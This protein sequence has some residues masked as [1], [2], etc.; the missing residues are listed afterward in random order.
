MKQTKLNFDLSFLDQN[1]V[2]NFDQIKQNNKTLLSKK[3]IDNSGSALA[4]ILRFL[5]QIFV[6]ILAYGLVYAALRAIIECIG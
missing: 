2:A 5:D 3:P 6:N 1:N 4:G